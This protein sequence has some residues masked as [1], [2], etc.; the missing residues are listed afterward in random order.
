[1]QRIPLEP[2][3]VVESRQGR[4]E[5]RNLIVL[6]VLDADYVLLADG[7]TRKLS[8]PKKK[9]KMHVHAKP[10]LLDLTQS[11]PSGHLQDSDLRTFLEENGLGLKKPLCKED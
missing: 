1:M 2:G 8:H 11:F 4:D 7:L 10:Y 3:R 9:K 5:G 6:T